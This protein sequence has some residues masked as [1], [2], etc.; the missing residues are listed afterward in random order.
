MGHLL[1]YE[2]FFVILSPQ[3]IAAWEEAVSISLIKPG[4][5]PEVET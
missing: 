5:I 3:A 4:Q 2:G 1:T